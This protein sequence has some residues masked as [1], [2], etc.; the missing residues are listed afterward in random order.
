MGASGV[1][2]GA[3]VTATTQAFVAGDGGCLPTFAAGLL[4]GANIVAGTNQATTVQMTLGYAITSTIVGGLNDLWALHSNLCNIY[5]A[6]CYT[7]NCT[8]APKTS[9]APNTVFNPINLALTLVLIL[10]SYGAI[11]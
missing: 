5:G 10:I 3:P 2:Y 11:F 1:T 6:C 8:P 7:N 9:P 4:G